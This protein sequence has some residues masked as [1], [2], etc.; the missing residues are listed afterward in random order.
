VKTGALVEFCIKCSLR[1]IVLKRISLTF[2]LYKYKG[3]TCL[4]HF[5][6][7]SMKAHV[8]LTS[9]RSSLKQKCWVNMNE[10]NVD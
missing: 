1:G 3:Q 5:S 6:S 7:C 10:A 8:T 2:E 9:Y 4:S